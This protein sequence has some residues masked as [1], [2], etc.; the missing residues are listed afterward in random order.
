MTKPICKGEQRWKFWR[1]EMPWKDYP[2]GYLKYY[3]NQ[4]NRA[5]RRFFNNEIKK[6]LT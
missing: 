5:K 4:M 1:D 6:E 3:K 2:T